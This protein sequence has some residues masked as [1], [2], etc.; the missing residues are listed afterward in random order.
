M[1]L[2]YIAHRVDPHFRLVVAANRDEYHVRPTSPAAWWDDEPGILAGRDLEAGGTWIGVTRGGRFAALTN[3]R[4]PARH[5][6]AARSRGFLVSGFLRGQDGA[7]AFLS[8]VAREGQRY[9]GFS[10]LVHD[11]D[12][13]A[14]YSNRGGA[15]EVVAPGVHGLSNHVLDTPWPKVEEGKLEL[16]SMLS[17]GGATPGALLGLLDRRLPVDDGHLPDTGVGRARE[18]ALSPRFILG[19][20]YGT[21]CSTIIMVDAGG[22]VL[23][24]ERSFDSR[25]E[26]RGDEVH[27]FR[28]AGS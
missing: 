23:F 6:G 2:I 17:R 16:L 15:P 26:P 24:R 19:E 10:L 27:S 14:F 21:R 4:D 13:L 20:Q 9:N 1:C 3:Y 18:R 7:M 22:D 5:D 25:G 11:G 12:V 28:L 8:D